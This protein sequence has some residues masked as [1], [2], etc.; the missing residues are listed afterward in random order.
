MN[1][2]VPI[3]EAKLGSPGDGRRPPSSASGF[4]ERA[5]KIVIHPFFLIVIVPTLLVATVQYFVVANQ[6]ESQAD[7]IV[8]RGDQ[9]GAVSGS[10]LGQ[11]L[12]LGG[13]GDGAEARSLVDYLTSH[14]A[15]AALRKDADLINVFRRQEA[16]PISRLHSASPPSESLLKY[17]RRQVSI[18]SDTDTGVTVLKARAFRPQ[19]A[20]MLTERLLQL[21]EKQVNTYN[22][23]GLKDS[24]AVAREQLAEAE[25]GVAASQRD[26]T[27]F[28]QGERDI[29]PGRT[30]AANIT[31]ATAMQQQLAQARA[32]LAT[33]GR[34]VAPTS[35]QY[36][37]MAS[38]VRSLEAQVNAAQGHLT[39]SSRS[40]APDLGAY[41]SLQL[42][43]Q[44]AAKRYEAAAAALETVRA[45]AMKQQ[46][47]VVR[48]VEPN[49]PQKSLYPERLKSVL[50]V[51]FG[52]LVA[53][54]IGWLIMAGVREHAA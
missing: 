16:D 21:G 14:D 23:R 5:R 33:M 19:D 9:V 51:F 53:Y 32:Q 43:Q 2:F 52:L 1:A 13:A 25:A 44:F 50:T 47:F 39:G 36:V 49:L 15:V 28:R 48:V 45:T 30:S 22:Q 24:L 54:G 31:M 10:G 26:V 20:Q 27:G 17:F 4:A 3:A 35:P 34:A 12:G 46:L 18:S 11:L 29:D 40:I 8:R 38:Q 41:E 37:A 6:Y 7:F 42:R